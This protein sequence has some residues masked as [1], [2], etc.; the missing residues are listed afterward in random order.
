MLV[1]AVMEFMKECF[2]LAEYEVSWSASGFG[3]QSTT[4][5]NYVMAV[6]GQIVNEGLP[7]E[8]FRSGETVVI[9]KT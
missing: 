2:L 6:L 5:Y 1:K 9:A 3:S 7:W 4:L 8:L